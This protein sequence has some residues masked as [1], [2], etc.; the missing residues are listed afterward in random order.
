MLAGQ[1][2]VILSL[3][4]GFTQSLFVTQLV[5]ELHSQNDC[6]WLEICCALCGSAMSVSACTKELSALARGTEMR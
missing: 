6:G 4:E 5:S 1:G 3:W 2:N